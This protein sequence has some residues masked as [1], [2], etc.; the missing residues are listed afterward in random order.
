[1]ACERARSQLMLW[2][3]SVITVMSVSII[4]RNRHLREVEQGRTWEL[5]NPR[6]KGERER[7]RL[8]M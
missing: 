4:C 3:G 2:G 7:E 6:S 5:A 1:M 8:N